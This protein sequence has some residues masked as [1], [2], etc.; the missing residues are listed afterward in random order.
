[1]RGGRI[2]PADAA[3]YLGCSAQTIRV[4]LVNG[5]LPVGT[6]V[7]LP[8]SRAGKERYQYVIDLIALI[9]Y[10]KAADI[11]RGEGRDGKRP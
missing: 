3:R 11:I 2:L 4:G 7:P 10:K 1:M 5:T 6:A 9:E 8:G